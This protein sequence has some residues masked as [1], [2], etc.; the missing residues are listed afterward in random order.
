[1]IFFPFTHLTV[2]CSI[3]YGHLSVQQ[4]SRRYSWTT[5]TLH[6]VCNNSH[7]TFSLTLG[8][9]SFLSF[10]SCQ[11]DS[12]R[13]LSYRSH[14]VS[15]LWQFI[16]LSTLPSI[17]IYGIKKKKKK[18]KSK[19]GEGIRSLNPNDNSLYINSTFSLH[20][21][22]IYSYIHLWVVFMYW[23]LGIILN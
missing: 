16:S 18:K 17:F 19:E 5:Q 11:F 2:L 22:H 12:F 6:T 10:A 1:M 9:H 3:I 7:L 15:V 20:I 14:A 21:H 4:T 23:I 8:S 13:N